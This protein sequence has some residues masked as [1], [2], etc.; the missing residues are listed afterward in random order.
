I[1]GELGQMI[2]HEVVQYADVDI[3]IM[4]LHGIIV[5]STDRNRINTLH[6]GSFEVLKSE[7]PLIINKSNQYYYQGSKSGINSLIM[8]LGKSRGVVEESGLL[9]EEKQQ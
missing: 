2:I 3:N 4:N 1:T 5:S 6:T 8:H 9:E 7:K